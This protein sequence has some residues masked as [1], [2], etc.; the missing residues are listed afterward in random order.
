ME[1]RRR[2]AGFEQRDG[3][4]SPSERPELAARSL[5]LVP[6]QQP[7]GTQRDG[8]AL[9]EAGARFAQRRRRRAALSA[10]DVRL[11][12]RSTAPGASLGRLEGA[13]RGMREEERGM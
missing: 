6:Q 10:L 5:Q 4:L 1:G 3:P 8:A 13:G 7:R 2:P 9:P 11:T 12:P